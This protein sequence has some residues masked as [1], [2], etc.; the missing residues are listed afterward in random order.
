M[1][2]RFRSS[3]ISSARV[4][5]HRHLLFF[6]RTSGDR[7]EDVGR[8]RGD[9]F[10]DGRK[11]GIFSRGRTAGLCGDEEVRSPLGGCR[12]RLSGGGVRKRNPARGVGG[13][14]FADDNRSAGVLFCGL[15]GLL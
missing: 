11:M 2:R 1:C 9:V 14:V 13:W 15:V 12:S 3:G 7:C 4:D 5:K 8:G 6:G 10:S